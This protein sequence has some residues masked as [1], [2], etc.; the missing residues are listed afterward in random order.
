M[1]RRRNKARSFGGTLGF[2][3]REKPGATRRTWASAHLM[4]AALQMRWDF[5]F[6]TTS[7]RNKVC[8]QTH[9]VLADLNTVMTERHSIYQ[10]PPPKTKEEN[11]RSV[12]T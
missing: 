7:I 4:D 12:F 8:L 10:P 2:S 5:I 3:F 1:T 11:S 6:Y 9:K